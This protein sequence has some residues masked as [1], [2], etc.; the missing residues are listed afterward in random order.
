MEALQKLYNNCEKMMK[1]LQKEKELHKIVVK[2]V[3]EILQLKETEKQESDKES[4][5]EGGDKW[6][7]V[8]NSKSKRLTKKRTEKQSEIECSICGQYVLTDKELEA[9]IMMFHNKQDNCNKCDFQATLQ[10]ILIKHKN[11]RHNNQENQEEGTFQC[12]H[13]DEQFS[14]NWNLQNHIRDDHERNKEPCSYFRQNRCSFTAKLCW[15]SHETTIPGSV[16]KS[17]N[18][19]KE[20]FQ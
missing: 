2:Y 3:E 13:C 12:K 18:K 7:T 1:E 16:R 6:K 9:H 11:L 20:D 17:I 5:D 8:S 15:N 19:E 4:E 10:P 14:A